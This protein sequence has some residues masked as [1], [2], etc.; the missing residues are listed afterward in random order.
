MLNDEESSE[1]EEDEAAM[2][3][4]AEMSSW[5]KFCKEKVDKI[6]KVWNKKLEDESKSTGSQEPSS[7]DEKEKEKS[8]EYEKQLA[9]MFENFG[10]RNLS[11]SF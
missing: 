8:E 1:E 9:E 4:H 5:F 11:K 3:R 6:E 10:K 2:A 7:E